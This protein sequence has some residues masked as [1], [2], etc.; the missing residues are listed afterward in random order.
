[1]SI[2]KGSKGMTLIKEYS[3][4]LYNQPNEKTLPNGR[5]FI[6]YFYSSKP[7]CLFMHHRQF[8][9][10][11]FDHRVGQKLKPLAAQFISNE[12]GDSEEVIQPQHV[13][14]KELDLYITLSRYCLNGML[15]GAVISSSLYPCDTII[16]VSTG[17]SPSLMI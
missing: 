4:T 12:I 10:I 13:C 14:F 9:P 11:V 17:S 15:I 16:T 8:Y 2:E 3:Q 5:V 1:M 7:R 6:E